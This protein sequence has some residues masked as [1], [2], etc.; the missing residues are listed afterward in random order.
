MHG[1]LNG[2]HDLLQGQKTHIVLSSNDDAMPKY[3]GQTLLKM[4][5]TMTKF[6]AKDFTWLGEKSKKT[7]QNKLKY[8]HDALIEKDNKKATLTS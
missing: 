5:A 4:Y 6:E 3:K 1:C 7:S 2:L 8:P